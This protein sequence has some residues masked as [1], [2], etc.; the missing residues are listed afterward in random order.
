VP[1]VGPPIWRPWLLRIQSPAEMCSCVPGTTERGLPTWPV[2][3][4]KGS[5]C[6]Q[7]TFSPWPWKE[8]EGSFL[9][10]KPKS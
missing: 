2:E 9:L 10:L 7:W 5:S 4:I 8:D 3:D 6:C 1:P